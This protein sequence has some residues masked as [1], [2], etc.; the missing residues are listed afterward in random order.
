MPKAAHL[1]VCRLSI[2]NRYCLFDRI[3]EPDAALSRKETSYDPE[4]GMSRL[5]LAVS[6]EENIMKRRLIAILLTAAMF[7]V[8]KCNSGYVNLHSKLLLIRYKY[9][10][11]AARV[12]RE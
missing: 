6:K 5:I 12:L 4:T 3:K 1:M 2:R 10:N 8:C 11:L 7:I 9:H